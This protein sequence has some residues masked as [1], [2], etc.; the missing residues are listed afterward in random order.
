VT[1]DPSNDARIVHGGDEARAAARVDASQ[2]IR[3]ELQGNGSFDLFTRG[4][5]YT[6]MRHQPTLP[7]PLSRTA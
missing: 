5:S 4:M 6:V 2:H 1:E 7:C 3:L